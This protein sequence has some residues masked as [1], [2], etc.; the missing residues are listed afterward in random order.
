MNRAIYEAPEI[1]VQEIKIENRLM[2]VSNATREC[3]LS[4][5]RSN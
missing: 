4:S 2:L 3:G 5:R 1:F